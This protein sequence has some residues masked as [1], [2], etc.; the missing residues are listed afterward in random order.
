MDTKVDTTFGN[1]VQQTQNL[2]SN[3]GIADTGEGG[4][5]R[6]SFGKTNEEDKAVILSEGARHR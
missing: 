4:V 2:T 5:E 6:K 3:N 1:R